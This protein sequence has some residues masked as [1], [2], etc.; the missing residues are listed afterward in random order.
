MMFNPYDDAR[1]ER[2][3]GNRG[4]KRGNP[5]RDSRKEQRGTRTVTAAALESAPMSA[6]FENVETVENHLI[7]RRSLTHQQ[8]LESKRVE[9]ETEPRRGYQLIWHQIGLERGRR[10][11]KIAGGRLTKIVQGRVYVTDGELV[12]VTDNRLVW[13]SDKT[14]LNRSN[15]FPSINPTPGK[16]RRPQFKRITSRSKERLTENEQPEIV[17][18]A[19]LDDGLRIY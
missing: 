3:R 18:P 16:E 1:P 4:G 17:I 6:Y 13:K 5:N 2:T 15:P 7:P 19:T 8:G 14:L 12:E 11:K 9:I 10:W